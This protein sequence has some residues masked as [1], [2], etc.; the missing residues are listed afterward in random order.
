MI[1]QINNPTGTTT[2]S[3]SCASSGLACK[4]GGTCVQSLSGSYTCDCS[5]GWMG[6][7]CSTPNG[8]TTVSPNNN[9]ICATSNPCL[10]GKIFN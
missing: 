3:P 5:A 2:S 7:D 9:N 1:C 8:A 6:L 10:N 4:M